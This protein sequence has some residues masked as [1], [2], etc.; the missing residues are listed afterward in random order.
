MGRPQDCTKGSL[1]KPAVLGTA[2]QLPR[3]VSKVRLNDVMQDEI[4][5]SA[6]SC[7]PKG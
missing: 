5:V 7:P 1:E 6:R 3:C 2:G 4:P